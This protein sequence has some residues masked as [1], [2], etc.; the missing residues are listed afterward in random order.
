MYLNGNCLFVFLSNHIKCK[1]KLAL[2][3]YVIDSIL[4]LND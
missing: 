4:I 2:E 1:L 3:N